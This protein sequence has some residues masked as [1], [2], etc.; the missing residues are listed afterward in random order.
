MVMFITL[1]P[2]SSTLS[3][4]FLI[5]V[6]DGYRLVEQNIKRNP[7]FIY[8]TTRSDWASKLYFLL[9]LSEKTS[10]FYGFTLQGI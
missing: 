10:K 9:R 6:H 1:R 7:Y 3:D 2:C 8:K 5:V 4:T